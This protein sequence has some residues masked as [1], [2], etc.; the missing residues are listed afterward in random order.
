MRF[1]DVRNA[2]GKSFCDYLLTGDAFFRERYLSV[3]VPEEFEEYAEGRR[4]FYE[5]FVDIF[6]DF[7][8]SRDL[9]TVVFLGK[10]LN[11]LGYYFEAHE[12]VEKYWLNYEGRLKRFLQALI[13]V[14]IANLH[15]EGGNLV[16]Y[17]R[18]RELALGNLSD[19]DGFTLGVNV[20]RLKEEL[21]NAEDFLVIL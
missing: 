11:N 2:L 4:N 16:G 6:S 5:T 7:L 9:E 1:V 17:R 12:V 21:R 8:P 13:Q 19:F 3:K 15:L 14:S 18:L 20:P 10:V